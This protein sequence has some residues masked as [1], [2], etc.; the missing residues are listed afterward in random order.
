MKLRGG[1]TDKAEIE[2]E[3]TK[4]EKEGRETYDQ[5][6]RSRLEWEDRDAGK[7]KTG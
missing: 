7:G 4:K 6:K 2:S 3:R 1:I 5:T